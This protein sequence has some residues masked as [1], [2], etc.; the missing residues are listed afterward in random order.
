VELT[1][2]LPI[3]H[4]GMVLNE[5]ERQ[6]LKQKF[7]AFCFIQL[8]ILRSL[9]LI[10]GHGFQQHYN[11]LPRIHSPLACLSSKPISAPYYKSH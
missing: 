6:L 3:Y 10:K 2:T 11:N 9:K 5:A 8:N 1:I 7:R 4:H